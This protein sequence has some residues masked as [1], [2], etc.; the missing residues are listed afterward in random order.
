MAQNLNV[1]LNLRVEPSNYE[2]HRAMN[3]ERSGAMQMT[4]PVRNG[5]FNNIKT[6][7]KYESD[8]KYR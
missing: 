5:E 7:M 3:V 4:Q 2:Y 6:G 8:S 1:V